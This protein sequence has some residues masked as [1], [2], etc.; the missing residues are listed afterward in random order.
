M[1]GIAG[2]QLQN[3]SGRTSDRATRETA[4]PQPHRHTARGRLKLHIGEGRR[5]ELKARPGAITG[6]WTGSGIQTLSGYSQLYQ[7][8]ARIAIFRSAAHEPWSP[9]V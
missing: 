4:H 1:V 9:L 7:E 8:C 2:L 5:P 3:Q 6:V